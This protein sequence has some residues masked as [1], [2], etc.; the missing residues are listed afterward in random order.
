[1]TETVAEP[2]RMWRTWHVTWSTL[3][4]SNCSSS[5][6]LS[7][8]PMSLTILLIKFSMNFGLANKSE[9]RVGARKVGGGGGGGATRVISNLSRQQYKI[10]EYVIDPPPPPCSHPP[11][12]P[13]APSPQ[14]QRPEEELQ[15][16]QWRRGT[17][18]ITERREYKTTVKVDRHTDNRRDRCAVDTD[19]QRDGETD[20]RHI[21]RQRDK[22]H[23]RDRWKTN[24][25]TE[26]NTQTD[27]DKHTDRQRQ[28]E[29]HARQT[30][31]TDE[32]E[33][34]R[35]RQTE[36]DIQDRR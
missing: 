15:R 7:T 22:L 29:R 2:Q 4:T 21:D 24:T 8:R 18:I 28:R 6:P 35:Q 26:T 13:L 36:T 16:R 10:G 20:S 27:R 25:Q 34:D 12:P 31:E 14:Q 17:A 9:P 5:K 11:T 32:R 19:I 33:T 30:I 23:G 3:C 1:M